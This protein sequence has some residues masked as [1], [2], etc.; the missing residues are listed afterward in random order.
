VD[1]VLVGTGSA[2]AAT[3]DTYRGEVVTAAGA[4]AGGIVGADGGGGLWRR[5]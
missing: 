3:G 4:W 2:V 1:G 5:P